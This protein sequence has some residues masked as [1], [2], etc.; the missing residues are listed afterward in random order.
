MALIRRVELQVTRKCK[1]DAGHPSRRQVAR[2]E[3]RIP[4][5]TLL[6]HIENDLARRADTY[7]QRGLELGSRR[8][9]GQPRAVDQ[10]AQLVVQEVKEGRR[11]E[12]LARVIRRL[13]H[14]R[15]EAEVV[16]L[17]RKGVPPRVHIGPEGK[18]CAGVYGPDVNRLVEELQSPA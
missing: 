1:Y 3:E 2:P 10:E 12:E 18:H 7:L 9:Q 4:R 14:L 6:S 16:Q 11:A 15:G 8:L 17:G 5:A 13:F